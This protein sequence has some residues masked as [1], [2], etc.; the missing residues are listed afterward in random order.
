MQAARNF[1]NTKK[2]GQQYRTSAPKVNKKRW[3]RADQHTRADIPKVQ[4]PIQHEPISVAISESSSIARKLVPQLKLTLTF[5]DTQDNKGFPK[6]TSGTAQVISNGLTV[7][8]TIERESTPWQK[9]HSQGLL[10]S[11]ASTS[12]DNSTLPE[13]TTLDKEW[14]KKSKRSWMQG[15]SLNQKLTVKKHCVICGQE[16]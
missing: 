3:T 12:E 9:D 15:R 16:F 14:P 10:H 7:Q 5:A 8:I 6:Q 1:R 13:G 2:K 11:E 4:S